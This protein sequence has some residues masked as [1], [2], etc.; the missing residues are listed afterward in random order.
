MATGIVA[1]V[2]PSTLE[3]MRLLIFITLPDD[4]GLFTALTAEVP[5][6][7]AGAVFAVMVAKLTILGADIFSRLLA[8]YQ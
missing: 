5:V 6:N 8:T 4:A 7:N 1:E 2:V 3:I